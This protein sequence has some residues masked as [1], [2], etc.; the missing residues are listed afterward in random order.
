MFLSQ[1]ASVNNIRIYRLWWTAVPLNHIKCHLT[2]VKVVYGER[3]AACVH[4]FTCWSRSRKRPHCGY[5]RETARSCWLRRHA[6]NVR[7]LMLFLLATFIVVVRR[8]FVCVSSDLEYRLPLDA[9]CPEFLYNCLSCIVSQSLLA[10]LQRCVLYNALRH[11]VDTVYAD[12]LLLVP[13]I[14]FGIFDYGK[15]KGPFPCSSW[16]RL[17]RYCFRATQRDISDRQ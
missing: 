11:I 10:F 3:M 12:P 17:L 16:G 13:N 9:C 14:C 5:T 4:L 8:L 6:D 1:L 7:E 15:V 2:V